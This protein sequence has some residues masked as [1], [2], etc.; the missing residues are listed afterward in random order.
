[1][2]HM[3]ESKDIE[4]IPFLDCC[5][6]SVVK[7]RSSPTGLDVDGFRRLHPNR[8]WE[9]WESGPRDT[10]QTLAYRRVSVLDSAVVM[11]L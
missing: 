3:C 9:G 8:F 7:L 5:G 2:S 11:G 4:E 10:L 6:E 1:M